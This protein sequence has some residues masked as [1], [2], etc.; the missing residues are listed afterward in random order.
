[1]F[2]FSLLKFIVNGKQII[3]SLDFFIYSIALLCFV[4]EE[5][6]HFVQLFVHFVSF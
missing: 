4:H 3:V 2:P 1:M 6:V 5:R